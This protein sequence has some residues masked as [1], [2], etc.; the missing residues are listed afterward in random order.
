[1]PSLNTIITVTPQLAA[2]H[3]LLINKKPQ[4]KTQ[5]QHHLQGTML[6][7]GSERSAFS[8]SNIINILLIQNHLN[9]RSSYKE[10]AN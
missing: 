2:V 8:F 1:M 10:A 6:S 3:V 4:K 5:L 7:H 9:N